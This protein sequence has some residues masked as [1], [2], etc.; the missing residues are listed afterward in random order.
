VWIEGVPPWPA[1]DADVL[2][3]LRAQLSYAQWPG[4]PILIKVVTPGYGHGDACSRDVPGVDQPRRPG[5]R[6][7]MDEKRKRPDVGVRDARPGV[8][9]ARA[10]HPLAA[11]CRV[12]SD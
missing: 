1:L 11:L 9:V 2:A 8:P 6:E 12:R 4:V 3:V 5:S 7:P 10:S